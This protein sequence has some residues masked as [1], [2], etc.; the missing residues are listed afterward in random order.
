MYSVCSR[1]RL[2]AVVCA[3]IVMATQRGRAVADA[4]NMPPCSAPIAVSLADRPGTGR[5]TTTGGSPCVLIPGEIVLETGVRRQY[6]TGDLGSITLFS[7]PL[8]FVRAGVAKRLEL[9]FAPPAN[10]SRATS[11]SAPVDAA[12]GSSDIVAAAKYL[13][14]DTGFAQASVGAAYAPPTGTG[15]FSAGAPTYSATAN[16]GLSVN[17]KLSL[18]MSHVFGTAVG[19][20]ALGLNR[21]YFVYAPSFTLGYALDGAT[22]I[23]VKDALVSRQGPVLPAGSRGFIALQRELGSRLAIDLDYEM[24]LAPTLGSHASAVGFGFV[25]IAA[26]GRRP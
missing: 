11:G 16:L 12:R 26:P 23:L 22:T 4:A 13:V 2:R 21:S 17:S 9:G 18:T 6:T 14:L 5:T 24:N 1:V 25:W 10:Q 8:T 7:G 20:D 15:G 19:S 3:A